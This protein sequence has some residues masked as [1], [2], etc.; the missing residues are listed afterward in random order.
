MTTHKRGYALK[1]Q[2]AR[3]TSAELTTLIVRLKDERGL[4]YAQIVARLALDFGL[5]LSRAAV[6]QRYQRQK[7]EETQ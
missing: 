1:R 2:R 5:D 3:A 4:S 7:K 6:W